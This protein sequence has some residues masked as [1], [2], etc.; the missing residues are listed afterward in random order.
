MDLMQK[1]ISKLFL[2]NFFGG[3]YFYVPIFT[4]FLLNNDVTLSTVVLGQ[5]VYSIAAFISEVP[6]GVLADRLGHNKSVAIGYLAD[7]FAL[8]VIGLF[9]SA[10]ILLVIQ[11]VRGISGGFLS[12]SKEALLYEYGQKVKRN[13]KKDLSHL[14]S[15]QMLGFALSTFITG[16]V[17]Q[18]FG[19]DSY[20]YILVA[21][22]VA[23]F[24]A[25]GVSLTLPS[26]GIKRE[27]GQSRFYELQ[28][29]I[30]LF[31]A[32]K[33]LKILFVVV[34][35]TYSGKYLLIDLYQPYFETINVLPFLLGASLS[36]GSIASFFIIRNIYHIEKPLGGP[37]QSLGLLAALTGLLYIAFGTISGPYITVI[38]FVILF[39]VVESVSVFIS[40][41]ANRHTP[42]DIRATVLSSI[43]FSQEV[44]KTGY[45]AIF[46]LA[47]GVIS[48]A[49]LFTF[50]GIFL[51]LGAVFS[52]WLLGKGEKSPIK[53]DALT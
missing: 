39:S 10:S 37:R 44:F 52:Y 14:V 2:S 1:Q 6:T 21:T 33:L 11:I 23:V 34:G 16:L 28:K 51:I 4:L 40:D 47:V 27:V 13:Y 41:Y 15:Y 7:A 48:L 42:S 50:Y 38:I 46:A 32:T 26:A 12:G 30:T 45:K 29:S 24:I 36:I 3:L 20:S 49:Q 43:S 17:I 19:Q 8:L 31:K 35:L 5:M 53:P 22:F 18:Q 9:P 25:A